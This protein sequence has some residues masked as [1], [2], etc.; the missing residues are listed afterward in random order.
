MGGIAVPNQEP[1]PEQ[2][3]DEE[4]Q[5]LFFAARLPGSLQA[6]AEVV[7]KALRK[8][9]AD[10]KW[11]EPHNLHFTLKF[12]GDTPGG[13]IP[14]LITV[15]QQIAARTPRFR[16][17]LRG[18]GSFPHENWPQVVW[19]GCREGR[20]PLANL[21]QS[22]DAALAEAELAT[23]DKQP[24]TPHLTLGRARSNKRIKNLIRVL[25][26]YAEVDLGPLLLAHF[27][28]MRSQLSASGPTYTVIHEFDLPEK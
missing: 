20:E 3:G 14:E 10:I 26:E 19:I 28:L 23:R 27:S 16:T 18:L 4:R 2:E 8:A 7:Q 1:E 5:R 13:R 12:L 11:V 25:K 22:L 24:F 9:Q 17:A 6:A 21:G 15:G